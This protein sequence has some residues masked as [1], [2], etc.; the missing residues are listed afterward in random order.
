MEAGVRHYGRKVD[1]DHQGAPRWPSQI[2]D[3]PAKQAI[4]AQLAARVETGQTIG[5]GSGSTAF[6][7]LAA[8]GERVRNEGLRLTCV[9][10]S[11]EMEA[12]CTAFGLRVATLA[13]TRPDWCF[14]GA[15]EV[16]PDHN[17]IK[18]R[19]GAFVRE[20]LVF[21]AAPRRVILVDES[22]FV[23]RLGTNHR[24]PLAVIPEAASLVR[25]LLR[26]RIGVEPVVRAAGGK[27]G[28]VINESG[29]LLM[30][31]PVDGSLP[32]DELERL[33][34]TTPGI[35]ATG[36]FVGYEFEIIN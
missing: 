30:D 23:R 34:L 15:D 36:L 20:Q 10:T 31:L 32:P 2:A 5:V 17:M 9:T 25:S 21:A 7:A 11:L 1:W 29:D 28:G 14:D 27:D 24:L 22:K 4:A 18:G 3:R 6:V 16:D 12:Y 13:N 35:S 8:I 33:L 19:G 26:D